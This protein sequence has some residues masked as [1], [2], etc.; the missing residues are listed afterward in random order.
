LTQLANIGKYNRPSI[1]ITTSY[2]VPS[3]TLTIKSS[4][5][6]TN[7]VIT[8]SNE[9]VFNIP[10]L[11]SGKRY[12]G[13]CQLDD[14]SLCPQLDGICWKNYLDYEVFEPDKSADCLK[15]MSMICYPIL[16]SKGM[17]DLQ[18]APFSSNFNITEMSIQ[19]T[20][21]YAN[22]SSNGKS[23]LLEFSNNI[24]KNTFLDCSEVFDQVTLKWLPSSKS[25]YWTSQ[26]I[27]SV[28]YDPQIGIIE[29][30]TI[31]PNLFF[32]DY[33]YSQVS[34]KLTTLKINAPLFDSDVD[35][36]GSLRISECDDV[37]LFASSMTNA[38]YPLV[39]KWDATFRPP[40]SNS[41]RAEFETIL[42]NYQKYSSARIFVIPNKFLSRGTTISVTL[43]VKAAAL[44]SSV[45]VKNANITVVGDT[46]KIKF[47]F[48]TTQFRESNYDS[49]TCICKFK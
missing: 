37:N 29:T 34:V 14:R 26:K 24:R 48:L 11:P 5:K 4:Y 15:T 17:N 22:Y 38:I 27:L 31:N 46:P 23:I 44:D 16:L 32:Y 20:L 8:V 39:F 40:L 21:L 30:L 12:C 42:M 3:K 43:S 28:D 2:L 18:C 10:P 45:I 6:N 1:L 7:N 47:R 19:P 36:K 25:C 35:I 33:I 41:T 9:L 13:P 49:N